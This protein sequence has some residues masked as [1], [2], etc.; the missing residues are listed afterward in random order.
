MIQIQNAGIGQRKTLHFVGL[1]I[2]YVYEVFGPGREDFSG[3][4]I[5]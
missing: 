5:C 1:F 4:R 3:E 2:L